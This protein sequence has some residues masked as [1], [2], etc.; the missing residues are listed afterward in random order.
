MS[1]APAHQLAAT[2]KSASNWLEY[3]IVSDVPQLFG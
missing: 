2:S 1:F 3:F